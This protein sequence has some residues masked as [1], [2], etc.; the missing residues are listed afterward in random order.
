MI[1]QNEAKKERGVMVVSVLVYLAD[2]CSFLDLRRKFIHIRHLLFLLTSLAWHLLAAAHEI[3]FRSLR[4]FSTSDAVTVFMFSHRPRFGIV[5]LLTDS[6]W[7]GVLVLW[8]LAWDELTS[9]RS[10]HHHWVNLLQLC[11]LVWLNL[12]RSRFDSEQG[13]DC[14]QVNGEFHFFFK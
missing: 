6:D 11:E 4:R 8:S 9:Y 14:H 2:S 7:R 12:D 10:Q 1:V 13:G 5:E 3:A